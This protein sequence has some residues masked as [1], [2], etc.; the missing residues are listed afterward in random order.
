MECCGLRGLHGGH[1]V[2]RGKAFEF[3]R[4]SAASWRLTGSSSSTCEDFNSK[5]L[6]TSTMLRVFECRSCSNPV[7]SVSEVTPSAPSRHP[8]QTKPNPYTN[9]SLNPE[10]FTLGY[11]KPLKATRPRT[12]SALAPHPKP[13][14]I[15]SRTIPQQAPIQREPFVPDSSVPCLHGDSGGGAPVAG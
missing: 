3:E 12:P 8:P 6:L 1:V 7:F 11:T 9:K 13:K 14:L 4:C 10:T 15:F 2:L 5:P